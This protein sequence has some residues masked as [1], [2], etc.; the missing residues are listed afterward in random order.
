MR[1]VSRAVGV[2]A[3]AVLPRDE[4]QL[5]SIAFN[6]VRVTDHPTHLD[7][8]VS[9]NLRTPSL[10]ACVWPRLATRRRGE[11]QNVREVELSR[12]RAKFASKPDSASRRV[13]EVSEWGNTR[14]ASDL[15]AFLTT[16]LAAPISRAV[17]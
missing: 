5:V 7:R 6:G 14:T 1:L 13:G 4:T 10:C 16:E 11:R 12:C 9:G 17:G 15:D 8:T 3:R 2:H